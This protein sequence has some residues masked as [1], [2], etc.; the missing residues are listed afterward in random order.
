[1]KK[2][3]FCVIMFISFNTK[4]T[5][6][7]DTQNNLLL[8][9]IEDIAFH[10]TNNIETTLEQIELLLQQGMNV[11]VAN[12][13]GET[14]LMLAIEEAYNIQLV[15]ILLKYGANIDAINEYGETALM[16]AI[17]NNDIDLI[18]LLLEYNPNINIKA[19][20]GYDALKIAEIFNNSE[21]IESL[22]NYS[23]RTNKYL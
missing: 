18:N 1:M 8:N 12:E 14:G 5:N 22:L 15:K 6:Y 17:E 16:L 23:T 9:L 3:F 11:N 20:D 13:Y 21:I 10:Y 4:T 7:C 19:R 2:L